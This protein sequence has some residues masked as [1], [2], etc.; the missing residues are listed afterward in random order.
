[1]SARETQTDWAEGSET[2]LWHAAVHVGLTHERSG[3]R[4][5]LPPFLYVHRLHPRPGGPAGWIHVLARSL[6]A[7]PRWRLSSWQPAPENGADYS[8]DKQS[9]R[10]NASPPDQSALLENVNKCLHERRPHL[11]GALIS[12]RDWLHKAPVDL[13]RSGGDITFVWIESCF[14]M[15]FFFLS[16]FFFQTNAPVSDLFNASCS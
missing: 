11:R 13:V 8:P 15:G 6:R 2:L 16:F 9:A 7:C 14:Q 5:S 10:V 1:M 12:N 4:W 3:L